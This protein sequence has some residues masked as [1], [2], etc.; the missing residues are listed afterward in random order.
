M[1]YKL[2]RGTMIQR[3]SDGA[4]IPSDLA[5][6]DYQKYQESVKAGNTAQAA[7]PDPVPV[8]SAKDL[9]KGAVAADVTVP[10]TVKALLALL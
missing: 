4:W 5:N 9:A 2:T 8:P 3:L 7:D 6:L 1:T 10:A